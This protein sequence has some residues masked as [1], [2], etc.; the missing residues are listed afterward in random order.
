MKE[1]EWEKIILV[2]KWLKEKRKDKKRSIKK[3]SLY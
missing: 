1:T 3:K 2:D